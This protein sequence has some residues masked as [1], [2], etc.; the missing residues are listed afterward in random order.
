MRYFAAAR[1]AVPR[2]PSRSLSLVFLD[3]SLVRFSVSGTL[4]ALY[5]VVDL[6]ARRRDGATRHPE[7]SLPRWMHPA[8]FV[9]IT[10]FYLM[11]RP[12]GGPLAGGWAN[13]A[14]VLLTAVAMVLRWRARESVVRYPRTAARM[15][16]YFAL[17][18]AV[19]VPL[20]WLVLTL[21]A[22][23]LSAWCSV[24][25]DARRATTPSGARWIPGLW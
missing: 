6:L 19:G 5:G 9:S 8:I 4:I 16:F 22:C 2:V 12:F 7:M 15:L 11:I 10:A 20:G 25:E 1:G 23:A 21:P 17:P 18:L 13:L 24:R 14:G 3:S